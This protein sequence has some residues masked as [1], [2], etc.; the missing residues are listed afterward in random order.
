M[1]PSQQNKCLAGR[2]G[3]CIDIGHSEQYSNILLTQ[4]DIYAT[5]YFFFCKN[6]ELAGSLTWNWQKNETVFLIR[7]PILR[8]KLINIIYKSTTEGGLW[9]DLTT[10]T[11]YKGELR[12]S[13][14]LENK[15]I[16]LISHVNVVNIVLHES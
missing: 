6:G 1:L 14:K 9:N 8:I 7:G 15:T 3:I 16:L 4:Y 5:K 11:G 2:L 12:K 13:G 10:S